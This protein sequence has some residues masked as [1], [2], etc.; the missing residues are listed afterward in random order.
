MFECPICYQNFSEKNTAR[1]LK[2]GHKFCNKCLKV[3]LMGNPTC[4]VC[5]GV[6]GLFLCSVPGVAY[7]HRGGWNRRKVQERWD[8]WKLRAK[9]EESDTTASLLVN[10]QDSKITLAFWERANDLVPMMG[11][12]VFSLDSMAWCM[13][14]EETLCMCINAGFGDNRHLLLLFN[15]REHNI[16]A[17]LDVI[18]SNSKDS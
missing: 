12:K 3:W 17:L 4:P 11:P 5:R 2:C 16:E 6:I 10:A 7:M 9:A 18:F 8:K 15:C 1:W 14:V 13:A